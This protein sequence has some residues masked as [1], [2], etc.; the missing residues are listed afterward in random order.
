MWL[1]AGTTQCLTVPYVMMCTTRDILYGNGAM[2]LSSANQGHNGP[3]R[4]LQNSRYSI[5]HSLHALPA[6]DDHSSLYHLDDE[7]PAVQSN[8]QDMPF[9]K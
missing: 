3:V 1:E 4:R 7:L 2:G 6:N 9:I 8:I 5:S